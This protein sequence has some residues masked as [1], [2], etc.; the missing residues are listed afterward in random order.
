MSKNPLNITQQEADWLINL[1]KSAVDS[2]PIPFPSMGGKERAELTALEGR[3]HFILDV[4]QG[5]I[6]LEKVMNQLRGRQ[7]VVLMRLD[8]GGPPHRNPDDEEIISPHLHVYREGYGDKW[9]F[10][11]PQEL[12]ESLGNPR[13]ALYAFM[14]YCRI[15]EPPVFTFDLFNHD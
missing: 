3:E 5:G 15:I 7:A 12:S 2:V 13:D 9:A 1:E 8:W 11:L 14:A 4:R 6:A 10:P